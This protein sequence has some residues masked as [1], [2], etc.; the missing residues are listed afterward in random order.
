MFVSWRIRKGEK[1]WSL[2]L[3]S[4]ESPV[5]M[6]ENLDRINLY[7]WYVADYHVQRKNQ[8]T[9]YPAAKWIPEISLTK[10]LRWSFL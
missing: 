2:S 4:S 8:C 10:Q 5:P 3:L 6:R 9:F 7:I 1:G